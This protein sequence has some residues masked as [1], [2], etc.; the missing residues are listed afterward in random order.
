MVGEIESPYGVYSPFLIV[1]A[2]WSGEG[3][4]V[5]L[6]EIEETDEIPRWRLT[7]ISPTPVLA[8]VEN[9]FSGQIL[10]PLIWDGAPPS[11][12]P[13]AI[14]PQVTPD[15][16][17]FYRLHSYLPFSGVETSSEVVYQLR[18]EYNSYCLGITYQEYLTLYEYWGSQ[19]PPVDPFPLHT[20][21]RPYIQ[22][23]GYG[24][25]VI[26]WGDFRE[27]MVQFTGYQSGFDDSWNLLYE[28]YASINDWYEPATI[29]STSYE[30]RT[31]LIFNLSQIKAKAIAAQR[32]AGKQ[33][34]TFDEFKVKLERV[35]DDGA[36]DINAQSYKKGNTEGD[37]QPNGQ[38]TYTFSFA[39][40]GEH[41]Q[42][43]DEENQDD[44]KRYNRRNM[45]IALNMK[46]YEIT[47]TGT[48][49][50]E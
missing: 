27:L 28:K 25:P 3:Y 26:S 33:Q 48:G 7:D 36:L 14:T 47:V 42:D 18:G 40:D 50:G 13:P 5:I 4:L 30:Y 16:R 43:W 45:E 15:M 17:A 20:F 49:G 34:P 11:R 31:V 1:N 44:E 46:T 41:K 32:S 2:N 12:Q 8:T 23:G 39:V 6:C 19:T 37:D 21:L 24:T 38:K 22:P 29:T 35:S 10:Q 9:I